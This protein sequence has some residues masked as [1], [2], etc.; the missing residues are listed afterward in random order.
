MDFARELVEHLG[1]LRVRRQPQQF[2]AGRADRGERCFQFVRDAIEQRLAQPL[3]ILRELN[4]GREML[5]RFQLRRQ[6]AD[7]QAR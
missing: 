1:V 5:P 2:L 7:R 6:A 4:L 3:G